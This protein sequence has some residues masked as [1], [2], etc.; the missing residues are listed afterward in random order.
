MLVGIAW[1]YW[2]IPLMLMSFKP[3]EA[4]DDGLAQAL[5]M[6]FV[7]YPLMTLP[8]SLMLTAIFNTSRGLILVPILLHALHNELNSAM[9]IRAPNE[10]AQAEAGGLAGIVLLVSLW[11][12]ALVIVVVFGRERL[13]RRSKVTTEDMLS[14]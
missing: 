14:T 5:A 7:L 9:N 3:P 12:V 8:V 2:H 11:I 6:T 1:A 4:G 10:A 13:S